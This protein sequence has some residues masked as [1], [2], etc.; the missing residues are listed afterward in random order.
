MR[1]TNVLTLIPARN[2][3]WPALINIRATVRKRGGL[4]GV[5]GHRGETGRT[6]CHGLKKSGQNFTRQG[7][8]GEGVVKLEQQ[9]GKGAEKASNVIMLGIPSMRRAD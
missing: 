3:V 8:S 1:I 6:R 4:V 2:R 9:D 7:Q 5:H